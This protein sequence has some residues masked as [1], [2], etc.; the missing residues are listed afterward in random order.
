MSEEE[1]HEEE[2]GKLSI[3]GT[4]GH[5]EEAIEGDLLK[6][7]RAPFCDWRPIR[8]CTGRYTCRCPKNKNKKKEF[9]EGPIKEEE[10]E[11]SDVIPSAL[12]P[13]QL[14]Q[15]ALQRGFH[16]N[17][18]NSNNKS[19]WKIEKFDP[20]A[21]RSDCVWVLPLNEEQTVGI[22]SY[23]KDE[24]EETVSSTTATT[25]DD[26]NNTGTTT[27]TTTTTNNNN[28]ATTQRRFV[29]TLNSPSGFQ[30]KLEAIHIQ[31]EQNSG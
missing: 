29:H 23:V 6:L 25:T 31:L 22:I 28:N 19:Y 15:A 21:G 10:D 13:L 18:S 26:N 3:G 30:R 14:I 1:E 12:D 8:N 17:S 4:Q 27:T 7:W 11:H 20:P 9:Q 24:E 16:S 2:G 5:V